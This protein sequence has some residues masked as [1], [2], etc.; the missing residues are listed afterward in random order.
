M[1]S[2]IILEEL[3]EWECVARRKR[4]AEDDS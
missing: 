2:E 4:W 3:Q 1:T